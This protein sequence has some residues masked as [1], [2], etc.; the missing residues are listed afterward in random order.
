MRFGSLFAGIGGFDLG[1][2]RAGMEC[3][4]QVEIDPWARRVLARHW[5]SV[6]RYE[7]VKEVG[8]H[9][10]EP[11]DV[12][13]GGF[14]CQDISHA[15]K[16]AGIGGERS[17]LWGEYA[18][19]IRELRPR[20][21]IVENVGALLV[22][23]IDV[24]LRDLAESGYD[25]E[26]DIISAAA[27]GA[28][29]LRERVWI[30][31]YP[32]LSGVPERR[33]VEDP[34]ANS[35]RPSRVSGNV[36]KSGQQQEG[37]ALAYPSDSG[38]DRRERIEGDD[39]RHGQAGGVG[40]GRGR[41][42]GGSEDVGNSLRSIVE[43]LRPARQQEPHSRRGEVEAKRS[44]NGAWEYWTAEPDVGRVAHGVPRR[45]DRLRGLGN[46]VVPQVVEW[47]GHRIM[48]VEAC[49]SV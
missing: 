5:P 49:E 8:H 29:H 28:P 45:V 33:G 46:A 22:R 17:G 39:G 11:V 42:H 27:V 26:W 6:A 24:V 19:I 12:I 1:L 40:S 37:E 7:D 23:G 30:V 41:S 47:I 32:K 44:G 43:G 3:A 48:E 31:A 16:R 13:C 21:V 20:Y 15:G 36:N 25:A 18:R 2:E 9:N 38:T 10:L 34:C 35:E 4:W 14:P